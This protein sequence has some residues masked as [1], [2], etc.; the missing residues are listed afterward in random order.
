MVSWGLTKVEPWDMAGYTATSLAT[1]INIY[2]KHIRS[3]LK[4]VAAALDAK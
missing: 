2:G 1:I 4:G 3:H